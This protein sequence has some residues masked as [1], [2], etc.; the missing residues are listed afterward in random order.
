MRVLF[1]RLRFLWKN[2]QVFDWVS[3]FCVYLQ[4]MCFS[5]CDPGSEAESNARGKTEPPVQ[6]FVFGVLGPDSYWKT[7]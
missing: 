2:Q 7:Q 5:C 3:G 4:I 6:K 1:H